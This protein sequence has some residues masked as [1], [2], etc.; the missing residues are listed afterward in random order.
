M[1]NHDKIENVV[2]KLDEGKRLDVWLNEIIVPTLSRSRII[3]IINS[4][5]VYVNGKPTKPSHKVSFGEK[6]IVDIPEPVALSAEPEDISLEFLYDDNHI[7]VIN[8][9]PGIV[10]HPSAGHPNHT[11]VNAL[12]YHCSN[13]SGI[14]GVLRPGIVHRLDKDTSGC[15]VIAKDDDSHRLLVKQFSDH[16]VRKTYQALVCKSMKRPKGRIQL[17]IAR[18]PILR[19]KMAVCS[20]GKDAETEWIAI[21]C[22]KELSLLEINIKTGRTHQIRVHLAYNGNHVLGDK[23]YGKGDSSLCNELGITRQMLHAYKIGFI[24]PINN[25]LM[26]ITARIPDDFQNAINKYR[27]ILK[28]N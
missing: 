7:A 2:K 16:T 27:E 9:P 11:I 21:E 14:N 10:V 24:H 26:E 3:K 6:I 18:H 4:N 17:P 1:N 19:K 5:N 8:K 15:L 23:T 28:K 12:L 22:L 13:L 25:N 20:K